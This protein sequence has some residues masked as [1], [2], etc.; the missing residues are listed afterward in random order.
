[1]K[2]FVALVSLLALALPTPATVADGHGNLTRTLDRLMTG[3]DG[4]FDSGTQLSAEKLSNTPAEHWHQHVYLSFARIDAPDVGE[5]VFVVTLR[6]DGPQGRIDLIEFQVWTLTVDEERDA[7]KMAPRRFKTPEAFT[8]VT[9]DP[10][11]FKDF[12]ADDLV[13]SDGAASCPILWKPTSNGFIYGVSDTPCLG[14]IRGQMLSWEWTYVLNDTAL[15]MS[16][17]GRNDEG[18]IVFG[19]QDQTPWRLDKV[20]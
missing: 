20:N 2:N 3:L 8:Q 12:K 4:A 18:K 17:A 15:W 16:F 14:P 5:N 10:S 1:M 11:A 13:P 9:R 19:R 6:D 7:I